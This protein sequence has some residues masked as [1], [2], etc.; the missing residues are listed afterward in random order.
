[1]YLLNLHIHY[2]HPLARLN[3]YRSKIYCEWFYSDLRS[4]KKRGRLSTKWGQLIYFRED[5]KPK[6]SVNLQ[7]RSP[8]SFTI[9]E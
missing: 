9:I 7:Y 2:C 4:L 6:E 5:N 3:S 1:M 8:F